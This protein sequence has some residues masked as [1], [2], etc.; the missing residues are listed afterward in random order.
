MRRS[1]L[2]HLIF[3]GSLAAC[4]GQPTAPASH[5]L[6][7]KWRTSPED[8][9]YSG[10]IPNLKQVAI[11]LTLSAEQTGHWRPFYA[12][13]GMHL[14]SSGD[15]GQAFRWR[16]AGGAISFEF[17]DGTASACRGQATP[18]KIEIEVA[19]CA[20]LTRLVSQPKVAFARQ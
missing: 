5:P 2:L 13:D 18:E 11:N 20:F 15:D 4:S 10:P 8:L 6:A 19:G 14:P 17:D 12:Q 16:E 7:G 9:P 3:A 1:V